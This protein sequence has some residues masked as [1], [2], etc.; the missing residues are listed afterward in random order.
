MKAFRRMDSTMNHVFHFGAFVFLIESNYPRGMRI[1]VVLLIFVLGGCG[2]TGS[3]PSASAVDEPLVESQYRL[4][5]D[6][7]AFEELRGQIDPGKKE[8]NDELAFMLQWMAEPRIPPADVRRKFDQA[9][10]RSRNR[11]Q[12]DE[13][14]SREEFVRRERK[15]R[16]DFNREQ[17]SRRKAFNSGKPDRDKSREFYAELDRQ[18]KEFNSSQRE[19]RDTF[20]ELQRDR[21]KNFDSYI[22]EKTSEF[23]QEHRAYGRRYEDWVKER[24]KQVPA[25]EPSA[26]GVRR[27][28]T[29]STEE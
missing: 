28:H 16:E 19:K 4:K 13:R 1:W 14:K 25:Q 6:R 10:S 7:E 26:E 3:A 5:A 24:K 12:K 17:D 20:E 8:E 23:T 29:L 27:Q 18:R 9:V 11:F 2:T 22:R 21:R 15:D